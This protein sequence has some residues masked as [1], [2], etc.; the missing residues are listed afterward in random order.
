MRVVQ[1]GTDK[2]LRPRKCSRSSSLEPALGALSIRT[3]G[4]RQ[5]RR[6]LLR[7]R[8]APRAGIPAPPQLHACGPEKRLVRLVLAHPG[9]IFAEQTRH[10]Q[11]S[12]TE[13]MIEV[14]PLLRGFAA[15]MAATYC[16]KVYFFSTGGNDVKSLFSFALLILTLLG[17][18]EASA[19]PKGTMS[20]KDEGVRPLFPAAC[21]SL[22][23]GLA[24]QRWFE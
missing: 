5:P 15:L 20:G 16:P 9:A 18:A 11:R 6:V 14:N 8:I 24:E 22:A 12:F 17:D 13:T 4:S 23:A 19:S 7:R 3:G 2:E 10:P 21:L 1:K